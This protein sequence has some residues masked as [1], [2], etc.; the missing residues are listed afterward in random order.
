MKKIHILLIISFGFI[1]Q[2]FSRNS[3]KITQYLNTNLFTNPCLD[4]IDTIIING[5]IATETKVS[6]SDCPF[7]K[8]EI[9]ITPNDKASWNY[10]SIVKYTFVSNSLL[11]Y[12]IKNGKDNLETL[13]IL[14]NPENKKTLKMVIAGTRINDR[15]IRYQ[16]LS[17]SG[18]LHFEIT[19]RDDSNGYNVVIGTS[20]DFKALGQSRIVAGGCLRNT[21][22]R[23]CIVC[24][25]RECSET[26]WCVLTCTAAGAAC[27]AGWVVAC[28]I[29]NA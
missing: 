27:A 22:F 10:N 25:A 21:G 14:Y 28:G 15:D 9:F 23:D 18:V 29:I 24:S 26:W 19:I 16:Y 6:L 2:S 5:Q 1:T 11:G 3:E 17:T 12:F 4:G 20:P 13:V 7:S 8:D